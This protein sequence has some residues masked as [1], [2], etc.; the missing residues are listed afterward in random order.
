M[1][2][3]TA[4][5]RWFY[6]G[7][8]P[9]RLAAWF[10]RDDPA[11][12]NQLPRVDHY[13]RLAESDGLGIKLREGRIEIKQRHTSAP[14]ALTPEAAGLLELW[15]KWGFGL[16]ANAENGAAV[17]VDAAWIP[18]EK[19]RWVRTYQVASD[20]AVEPILRSLAPVREC[21]AELTE[22]LIGRRAWWTLGFEAAGDEAT[23]TSTLKA[24]ARHVL[25]EMG[26]HTFA[27][28]DSYGYP[29]WLQ[30]LSA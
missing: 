1:S 29:R 4:E 25:A 13:L 30:R 8:R 6:P 11:T 19:R 27:L 18:V 20:G 2:W 28:H 16:T 7:A 24:V 5:V 3:T 9:E 22:V 10:A 26:P 14:V 21:S 23:L 12:D 15:R 17:G